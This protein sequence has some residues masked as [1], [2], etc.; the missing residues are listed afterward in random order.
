MGSISRHIKPLV[1]S[2]LGHRHTRTCTSTHARTHTLTHTH[3]HTH[4]QTHTH[5]YRCSWTE[6][7]MHVP[8]WFKNYK[9]NSNSLLIINYNSIAFSTTAQ[10]NLHYLYSHS[11][12]R[13]VA[14][15]FWTTVSVATP[16]I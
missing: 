3:T 1:N 5:A 9:A 11:I 15:L 10:Q 8:A 4:T 7:T 13:Y 12:T 14:V 16:L 2:S 6:E